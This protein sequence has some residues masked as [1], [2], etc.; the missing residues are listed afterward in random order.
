MLEKIAMRALAPMLNKVVDAFTA[1]DQNY[2]VQNSYFVIHRVYDAE[3]KKVGAAIT[4][5]GD[6][7]DGTNGIVTD[8][9]TGK[10]LTYPITKLVDLIQGNT[11]MDEDEEED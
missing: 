2:G 5:M 3:S 1:V 9:K 4:F 11:A 7:P 8:P 10:E 6:L